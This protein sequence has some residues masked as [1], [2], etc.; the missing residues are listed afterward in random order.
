MWTCDLIYSDYV[1]LFS[2]VGSSARH[3]R[4]LL[5]ARSSLSTQDRQQVSP[6][7]YAC[8]GSTFGRLNDAVGSRTTFEPAHLV[9]DEPG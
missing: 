6:V 7:S 2:A 4:Y 9:P 1:P 3:P 5:C 8:R